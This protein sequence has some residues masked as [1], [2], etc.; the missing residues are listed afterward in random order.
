LEALKYC[1]NTGYSS[2]FG[3]C[4]VKRDNSCILVLQVNLLLLHNS[5]PTVQ[6]KDRKT[7][8]D[9]ACEFGRYRVGREIDSVKSALVQKLYRSVECAVLSL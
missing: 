6:N 5:S 7:P 3:E 1:L 4:T 8:L 9:L 2:F